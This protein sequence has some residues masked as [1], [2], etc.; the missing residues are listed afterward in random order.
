MATVRPHATFFIYYYS[1]NIVIRLFKPKN[2]VKTFEDIYEALCEAASKNTSI[3]GPL[4][5]EK[6]NKKKNIVDSHFRVAQN[7]KKQ[8]G[9]LCTSQSVHIWNIY[10]HLQIS[11]TF[12]TYTFG[13]YT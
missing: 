11:R 9:V 2:R 13:G 3:S 5:S 6:N 1:S 7:V 10:A 12:T 4:A 8:L